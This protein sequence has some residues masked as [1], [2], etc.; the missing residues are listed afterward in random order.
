M[1]KRKAEENEEEI[2]R[3]IQI[4]ERKLIKAREKPARFRRIIYSSDEDENFNK[5][6][7]VI[8]SNEIELDGDILQLLGDAPKPD[9]PL[10]PPIHKDVASRWQEILAKGLAKEVKDKLISKYLVPSNCDFLVAP[11]LNPE[12]KAA[13]SDPLIKRDSF[14]M[15]KQKQLGVALSA[16]SSATSM[17]LANETSKQKLLKPISD[18]CRMLCDS[19]FMET[20]SRRN[21]VISATNTQLKDTLLESG[22]DKSWLFGENIT[23]KVKAAKKYTKIRQQ[24]ASDEHRQRTRSPAAASTPAR[25]VPEHPSLPAAQGAS[26]ITPE[27]AAEPPDL[28]MQPLLETR[29]GLDCDEAFHYCDE[30]E[31]TKRRECCCARATAA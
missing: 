16:L 22:R 30:R 6:A 24:A 31:L 12:A 21:L 3:K 23:E 27:S 10:G 4:L 11:A 9:A 28:H 25:L 19:H 8:E 5:S 15:Q 2:R 13:L 20:K 14:L 26:E 17:I 18:A 1:G 7:D 29:E